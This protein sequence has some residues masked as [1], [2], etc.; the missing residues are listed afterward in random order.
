MD[1]R[2]HMQVAVVVWTPNRWIDGGSYMIGEIRD[3][4]II[5][6]AL[7]AVAC[8]RSRCRDISVMPRLPL[9][10]AQTR[11]RRGHHRPR[12]V[13][14]TRAAHGVPP[15]GEG[16]SYRWA[17]SLPVDTVRFVRG[18]PDRRMI[19]PH[20]TPRPQ[21]AGPA[22]LLSFPSSVCRRGPWATDR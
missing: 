17:R 4:T 3:L 22:A 19:G 18:G 20:V 15:G 10:T 13:A 16:V 2:A 8:C 14:S 21:L 11:R 6:S 1:R 12:R 5:S 7:L 9:A